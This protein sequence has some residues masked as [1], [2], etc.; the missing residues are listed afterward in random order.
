MFIIIYLTVIPSLSAALL[1]V[2][3]WDTQLLSVVIVYTC[4]I[5]N[6]SHISELVSSV[7]L[8]L[9]SC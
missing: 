6:I 2:Y 5:K 7:K 3:V 4:T 8:T 1:F 9:Y